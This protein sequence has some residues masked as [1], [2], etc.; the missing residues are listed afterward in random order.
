MSSLGFTMPAWWG[1]AFGIFLI[2]AVILGWGYI[3][4][5]HAH[6]SK[7]LRAGLWSLRVGIGS[8]LFLLI[9]DWHTETSDTAVEKPLLHIM[10]DDSAS[11]GHTDSPGGKTR[12]EEARVLLNERV[13]PTWN[14]AD[15][16]RVGRAGET[17]REGLPDAA[18][19]QAKRSALGRSLREAMETQA[20]QP[21]G[22]VIIFTDG[23][24]DDEAELRKTINDYRDARVPVFP[25]VI[26]GT[27]QPT[28]IRLLS[29][30]L[31]PPSPSQPRLS[32][33]AYLDSPGF[34]G[35][36]V[37][38]KVT[39][40]QAV[41]HQQR[42]R[43]DGNPQTLTTEFVSPY[44]G[45]HFY[46]IS[47][48][49][50]PGEA[51]HANNS[52]MAA[53]DLIREPI[54]VLYMEGSE[55]AETGFLRDGL[56]AD[57]EME[58]TCLHFPGATSLEAL[59]RQALQVRGKDTRIF[60]DATGRD[61]P[62][63]C[64]PTRGYPLTL[65]GLLKYD[66]V[67]FSDIIKEAYSSEQLDATVAFVEEFGGGFVMV[68]GQTSFGAGD[69]QKTVI[70]KLMPIEVSNRSDPLWNRVQVAVTETGW[71]HPLM[72]VGA[73]AAET[74]EA[75][76][77][78]FPGF[79]GLNY[80]PRA[81]PGA[82]VLARTAQQIRGR[83]SLVLLAVQQIGRGRTMAFTSDTTRDWG[84]DFETRWGPNGRDNTYFRKFWN[85]TIRWLAADR[86]A[87][88]SG[89]AILETSTGQAMPGES[90]IVRVPA[91]SPTAH[92]NL[93]VTVTSPEGKAT[94][95][96]I[97]WNGGQHAW[98]G[99]YTH[100]DEGNVVFT[101]NYRN[102]EGE[103]VKVRRG[104]NI[105]KN[106]N[107]EVAVAARPALMEELAAETQGEMLTATNI[108]AVLER[109]GSRSIPVLWKQNVPVWDRWWV[110]LPIL[111]MIIAEWLL[112]RRRE[113]V[114]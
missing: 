110:L 62:S 103:S 67:I 109:L 99:S 5:P 80:V 44:R 50:L 41:L 25:W 9:L 29:A 100:V 112:R 23:A 32:L 4:K 13:K 36:E 86:I 11:M 12:F 1:W 79:N 96:P 35:R 76:T 113:P 37:S 3:T 78:S 84:T 89:Q 93:G 33:E 107:E 65:K 45:L 90:I 61:V 54:R 42:V 83:E 95:L 68:G 59:A 27:E 34:S 101:A 77:R 56:E 38:L 43:L 75:W 31:T 26:G 6:L 108:G 88:K 39:L 17:Y 102:A 19:P 97:Q 40:D 7:K 85:N 106:P 30:R 48:E 57:P 2:L 114:G 49:A 10:L 22:G 111:A 91:D 53:C 63:V 46:Q 20:D 87:R 24:A 28:D 66:V 71:K 82:Y 47:L 104:V 58:V 74:R 18:Q 70:D 94:D 64:H 105:R 16:L 51:T 21:L 60:K 72:Q 69:Y 8:L 98:E 73:D 55:P 81:K 92:G 14:D 52:V 15:H